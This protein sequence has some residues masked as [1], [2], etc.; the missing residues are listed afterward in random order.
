MRR[1]ELLRELE[2]GGMPER[3]APL[4]RASKPPMV[5]P[6]SV[7]RAATPRT[8]AG[9]EPVSA[10][11]R[12]SWSSFTSARRWWRDLMRMVRLSLGTTQAMVS[13]FTLPA[14]PRPRWWSV[15]LPPSSVRPG[16]EKSQV[17]ESSVQGKV[18]ANSRISSRRRAAAAGASRPFDAYTTTSVLRGSGLSSSAAFEVLVCTIMDHLFCGG[19]LSPVGLAQVG[20]YAEN[21]YFGKPCGLLDQLSC[22]A[23]GV[24]AAD[25]GMA[26]KKSWKGTS[27]STVLPKKAATCPISRGMAA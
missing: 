17:S 23:G 4:Y 27:P 7:S 3:L 26:A 9:E 18:S 13:R 21:V 14:R 15:W 6:S 10:P 12:E 16:V 2:R 20:Q 24:V 8:K 19:R 25:E 5:W 22:A 1:G 11:W